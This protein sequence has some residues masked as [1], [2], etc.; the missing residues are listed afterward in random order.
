[1]K[2]SILKKTLTMLLAFAM[3][4]TLMRLFGMGAQT[5]HADTAVSVPGGT[6]RTDNPTD[7]NTAFGGK[8]V[9]SDAIY[10]T[11]NVPVSTLTITLKKDVELQA[12][13]VLE[14]GSEGKKI[15][16]NLNGHSIKGPSGSNGDNASTAKGKDAIQIVSNTFDVEIKGPGTVKGGNGV[17]YK[18][19]GNKYFGAAGGMAVAFANSSWRPTESNGKL[20]YG[21]TITGGAA[22]RG[23][24]GSAITGEE[25]I[26]NIQNYT[27]EKDHTYISYKNQTFSLKGGNGGPAIGQTG[28]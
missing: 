25:W 3:V 5:L 24:D 12:P 1:M 26:Y 17:K 20:T 28:S 19:S 14:K 18:I 21:L 13:I 9:N 2:T 11:N 15:V 27:G 7:A 16:I 23:G 6:I 4:F 10:Q 22:I 8:G